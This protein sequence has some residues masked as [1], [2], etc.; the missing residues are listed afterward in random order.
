MGSL[1]SSGFRAATFFLACFLDRFLCLTWNPVSSLSNRRHECKRLLPSLCHFFCPT[2]P[3]AFFHPDRGFR[4]PPR[5]EAVK[6]GRRSSIETY[7]AA[8]RPRLYSFEH[9]GRLD[10]HGC[11]K[12]A[13]LSGLILLVPL[14]GTD[15]AARS[16]VLFAVQG[17]WPHHG[18]SGFDAAMSRTRSIYVD[19]GRIAR[20]SRPVPARTAFRREMRR[21][22]IRSTS[23]G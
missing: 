12:S 17:L 19:A 18:L 16:I 4:T 21:R 11:G 20:S 8:S 13:R 9:G 3:Q 5:A 1:L 23:G 15:N 6:A 2:A 22:D 7:S 10:D 14:A